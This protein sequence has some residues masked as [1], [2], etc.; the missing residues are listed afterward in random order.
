MNIRMVV[1]G[2][3]SRIYAS[4]KV[5]RRATG[6]VIVRV[7]E[8]RREGIEGA[9]PLHRLVTTILDHGLGSAGEL[10]AL[11]RAPGNRNRLR[12]TQDS[13]AGRSDRAGRQD[14]DSGAAGVLWPADGPFSL[15]GIMHKAALSADKDPGRLSFLHDVRV[16]HRNIAAFGAIPPSGPQT[17]P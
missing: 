4:E 5:R 3:G 8:F 7:I 1:A 2:G 15:R 17:V 10:A 14:A 12:R 13:S 6:G 11:S 9:E 16:V